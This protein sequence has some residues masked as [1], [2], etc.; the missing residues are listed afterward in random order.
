M[1]YSF[2]L[3]WP[4]DLVFANLSKTSTVS[5]TSPGVPGKCDKCGKCGKCDNSSR[6]VDFA[7]RV[8]TYLNK[9][10]IVSVC[11]RNSCRNSIHYLNRT[12]L[13]LQG[14]R[15]VESVK[16]FLIQNKTVILSDMSGKS[17]NEYNNISNFKFQL[18][19]RHSLYWT[20]HPLYC[21][22]TNIFHRK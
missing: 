7:D 20:R 14:F 10:P 11:G 5:V 9:T 15:T 1:I 12:V 22:I 8:F 17:L 18:E 19:T 6:T 4:V 2:N 3:V 21:L 13:M 16:N